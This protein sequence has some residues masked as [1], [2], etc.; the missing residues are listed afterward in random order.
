VSANSLIWGFSAGFSRHIV[1]GV[2]K[3]RHYGNVAELVD[4]GAMTAV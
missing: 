2:V 4:Q 1:S 3:A